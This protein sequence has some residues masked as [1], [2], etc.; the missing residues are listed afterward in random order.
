MDI[1]TTKLFGRLISRKMTI[2]DA[3]IAAAAALFGDP[4]RAA[5]LLALLDRPALSAGQLAL[6]ANISPQTAS[7]HLAKLMSGSLVAGEKRGRNQVYR[8]AGPAVA[9]AI[10][11]LGAL[12]SPGLRQRR[13]VPSFHSERMRLLQA[14][15]TCYDHL[16]GV[17]GVLFHDSILKLG[18]LTVRSP[19]EYVLTPK[20][21]EWFLSLGGNIELPQQRPPF[22]RPC[23]DWSEQRP[24]LAGRLA[25]FL[26]DQFFRDGWIARIRDTRAVRI[27][28]KGLRELERQYAFGSE[29]RALSD[30]RE[31]AYLLMKRTS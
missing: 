29:K 14:A 15:R 19:K 30:E 18:Y 17:A 22:A 20:G 27:T 31:K 5:M 10:E 9:S 11:S 3:D 25:A 13:A 16:A 6:A 8:L 28:D 4:A 24:H 2:E 23:I 12:S 26:L 21:R 7:F 1:E